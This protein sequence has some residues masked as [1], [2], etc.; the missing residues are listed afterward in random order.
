MRG[1]VVRWHPGR[2]PTCKTP[3]RPS[4]GIALEGGGALGLAHIGV[5]RWL[6]E[7]RIAVDY[8]G[9][10]SM[11]A[12]VG[13]FYATGMRPDEIEKVV[14]GI[15]WD[16]ALGTQISY[17]D[18][19]DRRKQDRKAFQNSLEFGLKNGLTAPSGLNSGQEITFLLDRADFAVLES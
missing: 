10:T 13:G 11:G 4:L 6:E 5:L 17:R 9:G 16:A 1:T 15:D 19:A 12:L 18:L 3:K 7:H 2:R 8:V 14:S